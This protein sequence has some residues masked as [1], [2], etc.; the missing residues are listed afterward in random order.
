MGRYFSAKP[1]VI[2]FDEFPTLL[3][4]AK[5]NV[6]KEILGYFNTLLLKGRM[7]RIKIITLMNRVYLSTNGYSVLTSIQHDQYSIRIG[8]GNLKADAKR[9][10]FRNIDEELETVIEIRTGYIMIDGQHTKPKYLE[11]PLLPKNS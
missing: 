3:S 6:A 7:A 10:L 4:I 1:I 8:M 9:M 2:I 11:A 5:P